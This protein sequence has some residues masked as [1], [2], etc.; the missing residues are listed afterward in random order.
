MLWFRSFHVVPKPSI[1]TLEVSKGATFQGPSPMSPGP[2]YSLV[3][4]LGLPE[5]LLSTRKETDTGKRGYG[6]ACAE[7]FAAPALGSLGEA[8]LEAVWLHGYSLWPAD[9]SLLRDEGGVGYRLIK[10][11]TDQVVS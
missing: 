11:S 10:K 6:A 7:R 2:R 4:V 8:S 9:R 3:L 1:W 5:P